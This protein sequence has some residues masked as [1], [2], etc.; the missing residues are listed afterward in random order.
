M[1]G[2]ILQLAAKGV[3]D[4]YLVG[5][6]EITQFKTIFRRYANFSIFDDYI[7]TKHGGGF[8]SNTIFKIEKKADLLHKIYVKFDIPEIF[9]KKFD[10]TFEYIATVLNSVGVTWDYTGYNSKDFVTL[11]I[12]NTTDQIASIIDTLNT[13]INSNINNYN[14]CL[15][16][17]IFLSN[18]NYIKT[19]SND[20]LYYLD[21]STSVNILLT[22]LATG[23]HCFL[24]IISIILNKYAKLYDPQLAT[25]IIPSDTSLYSI[26]KY[27]LT[28]TPIYRNILLYSYDFRTM[29]KYIGILVG[30]LHAYSFDSQ[31]YNAFGDTALNLIDGSNS[32]PLFDGILTR[33]TTPNSTIIPLKL[34]NSDDIRYL[35]YLT[36]LNN[37]TR[38]YVTDV[39]GSFNT[40]YVR[41][42]GVSS[43]GFTGNNITTLAP[44]NVHIS[45]SILFYHSIDND[46]NR[47]RVYQHDIDMSTRVYF[48]NYSEK[49]YNFI[50]KYSSEI[51]V[52]R[53]DK[54]NSDAYIIYNAY[55]NY[56]ETNQII[57]SKVKSIQQIQLLANVLKYNIDH[58]I[59]YNFTQILNVLHILYNARKTNGSNYIISFFKQYSLSSDIYTS[60]SSTISQIFD[61]T[62]LNLDDNFYS[63]LN[64]ITIIPVPNNIYVKKF[65]NDGVKS[66]VNVFL[67]SCVN[68]LKNDYNEYINAYN[69]WS[70]ILIP[71]GGD[72]DLIYDSGTH[73]EIASSV[74]SK[75]ALTNYIPLRVANDIPRMMRDIMNTYA[76][77]VFTNFITDQS[78]ITANLTNFINIMDFR[79]QSETS[80][81]QSTYYLNVKAGIYS[82]ILSMVANTNNNDYFNSVQ[83]NYAS[84]TTYLLC[85]TIKPETFVAQ[86]S[87]I[88]KSGNNAI[89]ADIDTNTKYLPLEWLTQTYYHLYIDTLTSFIDAI[90]TITSDTKTNLINAF[91]DLSANVINCFILR[92]DLPPLNSYI[93]N[94][95]ILLGL[96]SETNS[97]F[98]TYKNSSILSTLQSYDYSDAISSIWYQAQKFFL[99]SFNKL[100]NDT[101]FSKKFYSE[102]LGNSGDE[103]FDTI[104]TILI[105]L[106][107]NVCPYYDSDNQYSILDIGTLDLSA[108]TIIDPLPSILTDA[109]GFDIVRFPDLGDPTVNGDTAYTINTYLDDYQTLYTLSLTYYNNYKTILKVRDDNNILVYTDAGTKN[110]YESDFY[111]E[112]SN[113]LNAYVYDNIITKYTS[114]T[115]IDLSIRNYM[116]TI[117]LNTTN[118]WKSDDGVSLNSTGIFGVLD[119]LYNNLLTGN[120]ISTISLI[121][122]LGTSDSYVNYA[123][124]PFTSFALHHWYMNLAKDIP[125]SVSSGLL[126]E[127]NGNTALADLDK[128]TYGQL[129]TAYD[130]YF[131]TI[132]YENDGITP[133]ITTKT[134]L[135]NK[136]LSKLYT[137]SSKN[138]F[139]NIQYMAW[140]LADEI[141]KNIQTVSDINLSNIISLIVN[142][143]QEG[144]T[145]DNG[146]TQTITSAYNYFLELSNTYLTNFKNVSIINDTNLN[147]TISENDFSQFI[148]LINDSTNEDIIFYDESLDGSPVTDLS[149]EDRLL[150]LIG[151]K[152]SSFAWVKELGF[153]LIKKIEFIIDGQSIDV[154]TSELMHLLYQLY[155][156]SNH[157]R[158]IDI[159]I[160]NT[161]EMYTMATTKRTI[162]TL[163]VPLQFWFCKLWGNSLPLVNLLYSDIS[164]HMELNELSTVLCKD[165]D[166]YFYKQSKLKTK[167]LC[168]YIY[169]DEDERKRISNSKLEYLIEKYNYNGKTVFSQHNLTFDN[170]IANGR[171]N[172]NLND[173]IKYFIWYVKFRDTNTIKP[174]DNIDWSVFGYNVRD[175]DDNIIN[176]EEI[177]KTQC[178]SMNG[179][180]RENPREENYFTNIIP[181]KCLTSD[182]NFGEYMYSFALYPLLHQPSGSAN[183]SELQD[184]YL[185]FVFS[186]T[187]SDN[188]NSI[189]TLE[190]K[191]ELWG[192]SMNIFRVISGFGALAFFK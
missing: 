128:F 44:D 45:D 27:P 91:T 108:P 15:N 22:T 172:I 37:I 104:K 70:R 105:N 5:I 186:Q 59:H 36:Y 68:K 139:R 102:K 17:V 60:L 188:F 190:A 49:I 9:V 134:L 92:S 97:T 96:T 135:K 56:I 137:D 114:D 24:K 124:N 118:Y 28:D 152:S 171:M 83:S 189:K 132:V 122:D 163:Y 116:S 173:P 159:M 51:S 33:G 67:L 52:T 20:P 100:F 170:S 1:G 10:P 57:N 125:D 141:L 145:Q 166:S 13:Y 113:T 21:D 34:Y 149:L 41:V 50:E 164:I 156:D 138:P 180:V 181:Y 175:S 165:D 131:K 129:T 40:T 177:I 77:Y 31:I 26:G 191:V 155:I 144:T 150:K 123:T 99:Y 187:V 47:Y 23:R 126:S 88:T 78:I 117:S 16:S 61:S 168:Q 2:A 146:S 35:H 93:S 157:K 71:N 95:S 75:V 158:G 90:G 160:G 6:P 25:D 192:C 76:G 30:A 136:E 184:S 161:T 66:A 32:L 142:S 183:Y 107:N 46:I 65:F 79:D 64:N 119:S 87:V 101:L 62:L 11:E 12:Y 140:Y 154:H 98:Q 162:T 54:K 72:L 48:N 185:T 176:I 29:I 80:I 112:K 84:G 3:S 4:L 127:H 109:D 94:K 38:L 133:A 7:L 19:K 115:S 63:I 8:G 111:F 147:N 55:L 153:K 110:R 103:L 178:F 73:A 148:N 82:R 179:V 130:T 151:R 43:L 106:A 69:A 18:L 169:L 58:N 86:Y 89:F 121:R 14:F 74:F 53:D 81:S 39:T 167:L 182:L 174:I 120:L 85:F 42:S 143:T